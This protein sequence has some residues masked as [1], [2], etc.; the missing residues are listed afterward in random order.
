MAVDWKKAR[1]TG[2]RMADPLD[3][4][5][6]FAGKDPK[7]D[8]SGEEAATQD[9]LRDFEGSI[10]DFLAGGQAQY[11]AGNPLEL[12]QIG[13]LPQLGQSGMA[14]ITTDP[15]Y[16]DAEMSALA[17]LQE[18]A[19]EGF[20]ARDRADQVRNDMATSAANRGRIG[21]IQQN[22]QARGMSGSG[23]DLVAQMQ[24]A[25]DSAQ[26]DA[27]RALER[28]ANQETARSRGAAAAG[29]LASQLQGR[30]FTQAAAKAQAQDVINRFN[31][32]NSVN[33]TLQNNSIANQARTSNWDRTN[34]T[35]DRN[36]TASYDYR[37]DG[38]AAKQLGAK[39][40]TNAA[41]D[42]MNRKLIDAEQKKRARQQKKSAILGMGGAAAGA[43]AGGPQGAQT[44]YGVGSG[45]G[46]AFAHG[47]KIPGDAEHPGDD[48][49]NDKVPIMASPG[50][51]VVPRTAADSP[52]E[53]AAFAAEAAGGGD[54]DVI[55]HLLK[56]V[57]S[58]HKRKSNA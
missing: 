58:M 57:A 51:I 18:Q 9:A 49:R 29:G 44:G 27:I 19:R 38:M 1:R 4:Y 6:T 23:M 10:S 48:L 40:R 25:Q 36:A 37:R 12:E 55:G 17:Q 39:E 35:S 20:S 21:A 22:M 33:R 54:D 53:A 50:E 42:S 28:E 47:G 13:D 3:L 2:Q 31:T 7:A 46:Q 34:S 24:S 52:L 5:G 41:T 32:Q 8:I 16:R 56:A 30:D 15:R 26:I 14:G 43:Y 45:I 11:S